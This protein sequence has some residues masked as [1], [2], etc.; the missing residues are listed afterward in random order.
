ML[1]FLL[2]ICLFTILLSFPSFTEAHPGRTDV[3]G[4]HSCW[5]NCE[6]WGL[7]YGQYHYHQPPP[8]ELPTEE[9]SHLPEVR[10]QARESARQTF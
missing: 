1:K 9:E 7:V 10:T 6:N 5:T 3:N 4:G 2:F 8:E